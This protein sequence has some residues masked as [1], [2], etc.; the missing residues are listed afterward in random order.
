MGKKNARE[1]SENGT[2]I[3]VVVVVVL[4]ARWIY[5]D[6]RGAISYLKQVLKIIVG[7]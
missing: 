2:A 1:K 6:V 3:F 7:L 4:E 5:E